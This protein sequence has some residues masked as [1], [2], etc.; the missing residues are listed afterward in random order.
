[1]SFKVTFVFEGLC[2]FVQRHHASEPALFVLM[3]NTAGAGTDHE[4]RP[5]IDIGGGLKPLMGFHD[6]L[7]KNSF[8]SGAGPKWGQLLPFSTET[9]VPVN[10]TFL[11]GAAGPAKEV[12]TRIRLPLPVSAPLASA[13][14]PVAVEEAGTLRPVVD[15]AGV[16]ELSYEATHAVTIFGQS[17]AADARIIVAHRA[18]KKI[19]EP[20]YGKG[21][22]LGHAHLYMKFFPGAK[23]KPVFAT[24]EAVT[25][26]RTRVGVKMIPGV[27]PVVCTLAGG[28]P[29]EEYP[30]DDT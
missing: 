20:P 25:T 3:P 22:H 17:F 19:S 4:H 5:W 23:K 12:I 10:E 18:R 27:D 15:G 14:V 13:W 26:I 2:L 28:C 29:P 16:T 11:S 21:H 7:N 24:A 6:W 8:V 30:C 1:M 9:Q